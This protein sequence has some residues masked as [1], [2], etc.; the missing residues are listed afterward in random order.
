MIMKDINLDEGAIKSIG[1][2]LR[3]G[4][5]A[6]LDDI[7]ESLGVSRN[8]VMRFMVR[9][10]ILEYHAGRVNIAGYVKEPPPVKKRLQLPGS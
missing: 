8:A 4:E 6:A 9:W 2:G 7:A 1:L 3:A 10:F 5:R